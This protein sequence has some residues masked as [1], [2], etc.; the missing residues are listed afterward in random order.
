MKEPN[1]KCN[2]LETINFKNIIASRNRIK[3]NLKLRIFECQQ[4]L[5]TQIAQPYHKNVTSEN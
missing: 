2:F 5:F 3:K 4:Y 1:F